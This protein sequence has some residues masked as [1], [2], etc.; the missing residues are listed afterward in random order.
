LNDV[1]IQRVSSQNTAKLIGFSAQIYYANG[2]VIT[3]EDIKAF[4]SYNDISSEISVGID[5]QWNFIVKFPLVDVP[6]KQQIRFA[7]FTDASILGRLR[8]RIERKYLSLVRRQEEFERMFYVIQF[9]NVTWGE[10][11]GA[12]IEKYVFAKSETTARW[13]QYLR[14]VPGSFSL[15][16]LFSLGFVVSAIAL[17]RNMIVSINAISATIISKYGDIAKIAD[18]LKTS[19]DKLNFLTNA[20]VLRLQS[21]PIALGG[22]TKIAIVFIA[23]ACL[24]AMLSIRERSYLSLNEFSRRQQLRLHARFQFVRYGL[25]AA[26]IAGTMSGIFANSIYNYLETLWP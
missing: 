4:R 1:L 10:D 19:E 21:D 6:E 26:G 7:V 20:T 23:I 24:I 17:L 22:P 13:R 12:N 18:T 16:F 8:S 2:K 11:L 15:P 14:A 5:M 25:L 9:T 3:I